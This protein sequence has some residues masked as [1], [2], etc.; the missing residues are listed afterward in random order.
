LLVDV[1]AAMSASSPP[2]GRSGSACVIVWTAARITARCFLP[3][4]CAPL[5]AVHIT[6]GTHSFAGQH[7]CPRCVSSVFARS[8]DE[9]EVHSGTLDTPDQPMPSRTARRE[10]WLPPFPVAAHCLQDRDATERAKG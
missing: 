10:A 4:P 6:G 9:V 7:F 5:D 2:V 3:L 8:G 1:C